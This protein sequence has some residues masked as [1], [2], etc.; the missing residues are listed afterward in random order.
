MFEA[1]RRTPKT[2][3]LAIN[4]ANQSITATRQVRISLSKGGIGTS[5]D[6]VQPKQVNDWRL[7]KRASFGKANLPKSSKSQ[8]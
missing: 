1:I 5:L 3:V 8:S 4:H 7:D 6:L 2:D